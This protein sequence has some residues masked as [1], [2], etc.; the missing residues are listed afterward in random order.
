MSCA[1][2]QFWARNHNL[3][4]AQISGALYKDHSVVKTSLMRQTLH[5][6][7]SRDFSL[8]I[9]A[10]KTTLLAQA[11]RIAGRFGVTRAELDDLSSQVVEFLREGPLTQP[12]IRKRI[13]PRA[14][15]RMKAW[16]SRVS[17]T[18]ST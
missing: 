5:V 10:L 11:H 18:L 9:S 3:T 4:R 16:M 14:S 7:P 2:L 12:D 15:K 8:F 6:I 17:S 1:E 13:E